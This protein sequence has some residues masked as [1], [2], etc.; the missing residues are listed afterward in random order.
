MSANQNE[1]IYSYSE[2][3]IKRRRRLMWFLVPAMAIGVIVGAVSTAGYG[4]FG[5]RL[6]WVFAAGWIL[7][8]IGAVVIGSQRHSKKISTLKLRIVNGSI[9]R[10]TQDSSEKILVKDIESIIVGKLPNET[11]EHL[12][13]KAGKREWVIYGFESMDEIAQRIEAQLG[14]RLK[15]NTR[16][17]LADWEGRPLLIFLPLL[18]L[19]AGFIFAYEF[20]KDNW[21]PNSPKLLMGLFYMVWGLSF[22]LFRQSSKYFGVKFRKTEIVFGTLLCIGGLWFAGSSFSS[23]FLAKETVPRAR[24]YYYESK[25][26]DSLGQ[27]DKALEM[28]HKAVRSSPKFG[29]AHIMAGGLHYDKRECELALSHYEKALRYLKNDRVNLALTHYGIAAV[30][31]CPECQVKCSECLDKRDITDPMDAAISEC[32][33]AIA[34]DQNCFEA[35]YCLGLAYVMKGKL[36]LAQ[37]EY[38]FISTKDKTLAEQLKSEIDQA[39]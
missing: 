30:Y 12:L 37:K 11:V 15:I 6:A 16:K 17:R 24:Q 25:R 20:V 9:E 39:K 23:I 38:E 10:F 14:G 31:A 2:E 28:A 8:V 22:V 4:L 29:K 19:C 7:L 36:D 3:T 26:L 32:K 18:V 35:H 33:K 27:T 21:A 5:D 13:L 1:R 34:I